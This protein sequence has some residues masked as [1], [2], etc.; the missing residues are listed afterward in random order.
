MFLWLFLIYLFIIFTFEYILTAL[1][2]N[3][4][5]FKKNTFVYLAIIPD[6]NQISM[7]FLN[8]LFVLI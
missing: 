4:Y 6:N 5:Y 8:E 1:N 7:F 3:N 2:I